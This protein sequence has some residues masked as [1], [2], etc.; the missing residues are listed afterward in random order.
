MLKTLRLTC[1]IFIL[2]VSASLTS[3]STLETVKRR[4]EISSAADGA[5]AATVETAVSNVLMSVAITRKGQPTHY[6]RAY[7]NAKVTEAYIGKREL[8]TVYHAEGLIK[9]GTFKHTISEVSGAERK[10]R[11]EIESIRRQLAEDMHILRAVRN[12]DGDAGV[13]L[14]ELDYVIVTYDNNIMESD[15][16]GV[17]GVTEVTR[18]RAQQ[19]TASGAKTHRASLTAIGRQSNTLDGCIQGAE[20]RFTQCR[21]DPG[22]PDKTICYNN[23]STEI[24]QCH[25]L[26]GPKA[27]QPKPEESAA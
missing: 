21:T 26:Y 19:G 6:F 23:R 11:P 17:Y 4:F 27:E 22:L 5:K 9:A 10:R 12:F 13:L 14:A 7:L 3:A 25:A 1:A 2:L 24:Q 20:A 18:S 8:F 15:P 16:S